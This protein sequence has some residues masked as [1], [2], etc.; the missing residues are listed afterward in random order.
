[1][2]VDL[3]SLATY[4]YALPESLIA[5][6]PCE[7]RDASRLMIVQRQTGE[8]SEI[9]FRDLPQLLSQGDQLV[10]NDAKVIPAR[11]IGRRPTGGLTEIL[12]IRQR[13]D[14]LWEAIGR[15]GRKLRPGTQIV[16][17]PTFSCYVCEELEGP[18][19]LVRLVCEGDLQQQLQAHGQLAIPPYLRRPYQRER[20]VNDYQTVFAK[21]SGAVAAPTAALHFTNRVLSDLDVRG[22]DQVAVTLDVSLDT[23]NPIRVDDIRQHQMHIERYWIDATASEQLRSRE[24]LSEKRQICVGTTTCR[25]LESAVAEG[26]PVGSGETQLFIT[27]GYTFRYVKSLLTNFHTSG[28]TLLVLVSVFGGYELIQEAYAKAIERRFRFY[29][30]GDAMLIL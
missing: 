1:M 14:G 10:F 12:L 26:F 11:L 20:D 25:V 8:I 21:K 13:V 15:P 24:L 6:H 22:V 23:F 17:S 28:S 29:S 9:P 5:K 7:P 27:P 30:Y 18:K 4:Q 2:T 16:F 3:F 19:R